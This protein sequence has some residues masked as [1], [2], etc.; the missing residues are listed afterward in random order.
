MIQYKP[1][2]GN[3]N[4]KNWNGLIEQWSLSAYRTLDKAYRPAHKQQ[5]AEQNSQFYHRVVTYRYNVD[6]ALQGHDHSYTR[7]KVAP[8]EQNSLSG[9]NSIGLTGTVYVVSVS[10][11]KMYQLKSNWDDYEASRDKVGSQK[12]LFQV[13][14]IDGDKLTYKSYTALGELFDEFE[15]VKNDN[16]SNS[17][18]Q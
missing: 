5:D 3:E 1:S 18:I 7:G 15:L 4:S 17:I 6:L 9:Q 16:G 13:I 11:G 12:Q 14:S 10:G 8:Y 2:V